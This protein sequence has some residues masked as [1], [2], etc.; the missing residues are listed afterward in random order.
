MELIGVAKLIYWLKYKLSFKIDCEGKK[1]ATSS[2]R[3]SHNWLNG[4]HNKAQ[5]ALN[6]SLKKANNYKVK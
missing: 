3:V 1:T 2:K 4:K 5:I 6:I